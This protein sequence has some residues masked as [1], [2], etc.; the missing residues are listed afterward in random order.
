MGIESDIQWCDSTVNPTSGCC[1]C[2]LWSPTMEKPQCYAAELHE[3]RLAKA[4]PALYAPSFREVRLIRNRIWDAAMWPDLT[5]KDRPEKPWLNGLPRIIFMGDMGDLLAPEVPWS[6]W[7]AEILP[8]IRSKAGRRH[9]WLLLTKQSQR[10]VELG[11][12]LSRQSQGGSWAG[13]PQ[14]STNEAGWP[15]NLWAGVSVTSQKTTTR[16]NHLRQLSGPR[17]KFVSFEPL[18]EEI[19][20]SRA[21]EPTE[22]DWDE[23]NLDDPGCERCSGE[24]HVEYNDAPDTWGEDSPSEDNHLVE[25]PGC[26][27]HE[28][29][30]QARVRMIALGKAA[31]WWIIGGSSGK[32]AKPF[33]VGAMRYLNSLA[34]GLKV[35]VFNKQLGAIATDAQQSKWV[36]HPELHGGCEKLMTP[37]GKVAAEVYHKPSMGQ[38]MWHTWDQRGTGGANGGGLSIEWAKTYAEQAVEWQGF[39]PMK[40]KHR[41]GADWSEWPADLRVREMPR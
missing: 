10:L 7:D 1:G 40:L 9:I 4:H 5:G 16:L 15:R 38:H 31:D 33:G 2:E 6:Y 22:S 18:Q 35:S 30:R 19:D 14:F 17:V 32:N 3:T 36:E 8:A 41:A 11:E 39:H 26:K 37:A 28:Q 27:E 34:K 29:W 24:G 13:L 21:M 25:C 20:P 12:H 23:L